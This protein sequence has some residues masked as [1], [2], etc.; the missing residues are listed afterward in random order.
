[1]LNLLEHL[2]N[3]LIFQKLLALLH[4][5]GIQLPPRPTVDQSEYQKN[6]TWKKPLPNSGTAAENRVSI[7]RIICDVMQNCMKNHLKLTIKCF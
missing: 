1:M 4:K 3:I 2:F 6:F 5:A 7:F